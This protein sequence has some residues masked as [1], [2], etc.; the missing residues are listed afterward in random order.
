MRERSIGQEVAP[1]VAATPAMR[2]TAVGCCWVNAARSKSFSVRV[3]AGGL[4]FQDVADDAA[5]RDWALAAWRSWRV[6]N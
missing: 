3:R 2:A 6:R 5:D 1:A 4:F